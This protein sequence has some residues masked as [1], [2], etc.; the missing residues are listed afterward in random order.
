M[1]YTSKWFYLNLIA[2]VTLI[3]TY[4]INNQMFPNLLGW[5][6]LVIVI[7]NAIAGMIQSQQLYKL[8]K[9]LNK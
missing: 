3:V 9:L 1:W 2:V 6:G 8:K 5:F 7:L 4:F